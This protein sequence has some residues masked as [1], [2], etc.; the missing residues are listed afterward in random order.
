MP[1]DAPEVTRAKPPAQSGTA[2]LNR[3]RDC[4]RQV[5]QLH[6]DGRKPNKQQLG[7][8][9]GYWIAVFIVITFCRAGGPP[10]KPFSRFP[11]ATFVSWFA[12]IRSRPFR[13]LALTCSAS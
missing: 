8:H 13:F 5:L 6:P 7:A 1:S 9:A 11:T 12:S 10:A 2:W 4:F 3:V